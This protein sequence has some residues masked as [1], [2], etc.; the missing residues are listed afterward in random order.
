MEK[1][2]AEKIVQHKD[3]DYRIELAWRLVVDAYDEYLGSIEMSHLESLGH[4]TVKGYN[5]DPKV[6]DFSWVDKEDK[7]LAQLKDTTEKVIINLQHLN[8]TYFYGSHS[9]TRECIVNVNLKG[10]DFTR[11]SYLR[12]FLSD[13]KDSF[14]VINFIGVQ[15]KVVQ[16]YCSMMCSFYGVK[17]SFDPVLKDYS[18]DEKAEESI[19]K[20][21]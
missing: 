21:I 14:G 5:G 2:F 17:C 8:F 4:Y 16:K 12:S 6:V 20:Q 10:S 18:L 7:I 13:N 15:S 9:D 11:L 3:V 19:Q 1:E